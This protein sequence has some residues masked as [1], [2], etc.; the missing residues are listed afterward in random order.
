MLGDLPNELLLHM[1]RLLNEKDIQSFAQTC[2][3]DFRDFASRLF[4]SMLPDILHIKCRDLDDS[5]KGLVEIISGEMWGKTV[6]IEM[7]KC[8]LD[9]SQLGSFLR[10]LSPFHLQLCGHF[11]RSVITDDV[12]PWSSL[13]SLFIGVNRMDNITRSKLT[14]ITIVRIVKNW[15][16]RYGHDE[17]SITS[18]RSIPNYK[19]REFTID[20]IDCNITS[21]DFSRIGKIL[22]GIP[23]LTTEQIRIHRLTKPLI[24]MA[25]NSILSAFHSF[26]SDEA[27]RQ[28]TL[29]PLDIEKNIELYHCNCTAP[30]SVSNEQV[31]AK[32]CLNAESR[33]VSARCMTGSSFSFLL[34]YLL[35]FQLDM[36]R[37]FKK[38]GILLVFLF[39][40]FK[41]NSIFRIT[42]DMLPDLDKATLAELGVVKIGDQLA[43]LR[44]IKDSGSALI[45][46]EPKVH[47]KITGPRIDKVTSGPVG[48][49]RKGRLPPDRHEIYHIKMPEGNTDRT[50]KIMKTANL[51]RKNGLA[52]RGTTGVRQGGRS[53]SPVDKNS[54]AVRRM[55][56][57]RAE[58]SSTTDPL[59]DRLGVRGLHSDRGRVQKRSTVRSS[60]LFS[61]AVASTIMDNEQTN[62]R[63]R[64][65]VGG[66]IAVRNAIAANTVTSRLSRTGLPRITVNLGEGITSRV[67]RGPQKAPISGRLKVV[68]PSI[69]Q[70]ISM[71]SRRGFQVAS[72]PVE[73]L[74]NSEEEL[75]EEDIE[76][77]EDYG[78][79]FDD[80]EFEDNVRTSVYDRLSSYGG[81]S[82]E[83]PRV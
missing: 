7:D 59:I 4:I 60:D 78:D 64:V 50:R 41:L 46:N 30:Q 67:R 82:L 33:Q 36:L 47:V 38:T 73:Y 23:H 65:P 55:R 44:R 14:G 1:L 79:D 51:M 6:V 42:K 12:L 58:V 62:I 71:R 21:N 54:V 2:T 25:I 16:S 26:T 43:I 24:Q 8:T 57:D 72:L 9:E 83:L 49:Y 5:V 13:Y 69:R 27:W 63:V 37:V 45:S 35:V 56:M 17:K 39:V 40:T 53:V 3:N 19:E 34:V 81:Y 68:N 31:H 75:I 32:E 77:T 48:Q 52:V 20:I 11:D 22:F 10:F 80:I 61:R 15:S 70:R 29:D 76:M 18:L 74:D 66:G 28:L